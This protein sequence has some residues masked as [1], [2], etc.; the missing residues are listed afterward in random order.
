MKY[1][2]EVKFKSGGFDWVVRFIDLQNTTFG[3]TD[4]NK[5]EINI[6]YRGHPKQ[7]IVET[8]IHELMHVMMAD[9]ADAVFLFEPEAASYK[10]E[11]NMILLLSPRIFALLRENKK[12]VA[13]IGK[14]L[15]DC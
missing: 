10:K 5:K 15:E 9:T 1:P 11:E 6:Y 8:L 12:L 14:M 2:K 13:L 3:D 4:T 7:A